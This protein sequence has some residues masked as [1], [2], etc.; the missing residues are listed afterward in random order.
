MGGGILANVS[1]VN[2]LLRKVQI[3]QGRTDEHFLFGGKFR[4]KL[5]I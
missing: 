3:R 4:I 5:A 1:R 2:E